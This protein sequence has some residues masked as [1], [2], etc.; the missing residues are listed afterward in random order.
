VQTFTNQVL[1]S[2]PAEE[3]TLIWRQSESWEIFGKPATLRAEFFGFGFGPQLVGIKVTVESGGLDRGFITVTN[4]SPGSG[5]LI[6]SFL[7]AVPMNSVDASWWGLS[8]VTMRF[9][10]RPVEW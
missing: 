10:A 7:Q 8:N 9:E 3:D 4:G 5:S 1:V 6:T 2:P